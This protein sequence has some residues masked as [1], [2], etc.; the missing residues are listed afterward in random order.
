MSKYLL[1]ILLIAFPLPE[2]K[3]QEAA[4]Q[5]RD[6]KP[7]SAL[8]FMKKDGTLQSKEGSRICLIA[9]DALDYE[10]FISPDAMMIAV[11]TLLM[12]NLQI[13]RIYKKDTL[14]CVQPLEDAFSAK[15]WHDLS[16]KEGFTVN[17]VS[18]PRMKFLKW[19]SSKQIEVELSGEA[20]KRSIAAN[21]RFEF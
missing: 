17:D 11:E 19:L 8:S 1:L 15:L 13:I 7:V 10:V 4:Q 2:V 20:D 12:S 5:K 3:C 14:G 6:A 16:L 18:Y 9:D 21:V